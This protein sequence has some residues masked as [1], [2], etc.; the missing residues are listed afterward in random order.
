MEKNYC[1]PTNIVIIFESYKRVQ[2]KIAVF[3]IY[4]LYVVY[5]LSLLKVVLVMK[6]T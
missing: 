2:L 5:F 3:F 4:K 6:T 1:R